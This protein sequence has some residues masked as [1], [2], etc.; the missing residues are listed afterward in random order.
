M[1]TKVIVALLLCVA[2]ASRPAFT[3]VR[4]KPTD[5]DPGRTVSG[6]TDSTPFP[7]GE[8]V[9]VATPFSSLQL[10]PALVEY[11]GL[12]AP[13]VRSIQRLMDQERPT[14]EPLMHELR[15]VSGELS[16]ANQ[17]RQNNE[18]EGAAQRLTATQARLLM[19]LMRANTRLQQRINE[20]LVPQQRKK[21]DSFRRASEITI[22]EGN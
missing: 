17:P 12:T 21:F 15:T 11:L 14:T 6:R 1:K 10:S 9:L 5:G 4:G 3:A 16:A 8:V 18:N 20:V 7:A 2:S 22:G 13:Q 19:Q